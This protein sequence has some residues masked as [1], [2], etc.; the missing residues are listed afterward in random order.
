MIYSI[1]VGLI[2]IFLIENENVVSSET[3]ENLVKIAMVL[4]MGILLFL[5]LNLGFE[6]QGT[7]KNV[8]IVGFVGAAIFQVLYYFVFLNEMNMVSVTRYMGTI[9]LLLAL[10]MFIPRLRRP[11][12]LVSYVKGLTYAFS[13]AAVYAVVLFIGLVLIVFTIEQL[14][15][16]PFG[17]SIYIELFILVVFVFAASMFL[18]KIPGVEESDDGYYSPAVKILLEYIVIPL[19]F[20]YSAILYVYF[21][22]I[23]ATW[24]WPKGLVSHLVLWYSVLASG[25]ILISSPLIGKSRIVEFFNKW[26]PIINLP[27][28]L[29]MF[30]SMG[31]RIMQYGIT[32]NRYFVLALGVWVLFTM[33]NYALKNRF[34][35]I[36]VLVAI[37]IIITVSLYGPVSAY[38]VSIRSQNS[39]LDDLLQENGM[40]GEGV[41]VAGGDVSLEDKREIN[42]IIYYFQQNHSLDDIKTLPENTEP[43]NLSE[44][45]GFDY[46]PYS[47]GDMSGS[48]NI[49]LANMES[50]IIDVSE[51]DYYFR[52][53]S[54]NQELMESGQ[55]GSKFTKDDN[56]LE[57]YLA[58]RVIFSE[59]ISPLIKQILEE[60]GNQPGISS[61]RD[62]DQMTFQMENENARMK[63]I[64]TSING[65]YEPGTEPDIRSMEFMV[66]LGIE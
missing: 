27:I 61:S 42:N 49:Y 57:L 58:D 20:I 37:A 18:W 15:E 35:N 26:F 62:Q 17:D 16:I 51:Y 43:G 39:R 44:V 48:F 46:E 9:L 65:T 45:L 33:I 36:S 2:L 8:R 66:L 64:F 25:L 41:L 24:D 60:D 14:F 4:G 40:I 38:N 10:I 30:L 59:S 5:A 28:L 47:R 19:I 6:S 34:G 31:Q 13:I 50:E 63:I 1:L 55:I 54:W 22:K 23:I 3:I 21:I 12:G 29:M 56:L 11:D 7:K 52:T 32:E 53:S